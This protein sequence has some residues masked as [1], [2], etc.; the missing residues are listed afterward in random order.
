MVS[1]QASIALLMVISATYADVSHLNG[2]HYPNLGANAL[3][4]PQ[5]PA[6]TQYQPTYGDNL[7]SKNL[8][9]S[10][11]KYI[12]APANKFVCVCLFI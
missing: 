6:P 12:Q 7:V 11:G 3:H 4:T 1:E 9:T 10:Y 2:Y 8:P 5:A